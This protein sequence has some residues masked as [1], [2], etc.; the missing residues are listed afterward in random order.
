VG[1]GDEA[2]VGR[3]AGQLSASPAVCPA[4]QTSETPDTPFL[5]ARR[6]VLGSGSREVE[7]MNSNQA[8]FNARF[9]AI[10]RNNEEKPESLAAP[11][12][13][14]RLL[15][16]LGVTSILAGALLCLAQQG[17]FGAG[18]R[19]HH[20][21]WSHDVRLDRSASSSLLAM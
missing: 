17:G 16:G 21:R 14:R 15:G 3:E 20:W 5:V 10:E 11:Q 1:S 19:R 12:W 18:D 4:L 7:S 6:G 2:Q 13:S 8:G 9:D